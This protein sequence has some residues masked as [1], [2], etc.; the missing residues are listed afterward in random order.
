MMAWTT[1]AASNPMST[2]KPSKLV[3]PKQTATQ[4]KS[5]GQQMPIAVKLTPA[6]A[7]K[8]RAKANKLLGV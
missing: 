6:S 4:S 2:G 3:M 8:I 1:K 7:A 5:R